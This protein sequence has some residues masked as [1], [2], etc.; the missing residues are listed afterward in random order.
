LTPFFKSV[1]DR[2][3]DD[4]FVALAPDLHLGATAETPDEAEALTASVDP[5]RVASL[6]RSSASALVD[7][8]ATTAG[9]IGVVGFS[10][11]ASWGMWLSARAPDLVRAV[12][13]FYGTTDIDFEASRAA[14]LGHFA[15]HDE[16]VDEDDLAELHA[17]LRLCGRDVA[18][19]QYPGTGHWFFEDDRPAAYVGG[20]AEQ[21]WERTLRFLHDQLP[22]EED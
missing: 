4:G 9:P 6:V 12:V 8:P 19:H 15:E 13:A 18:F 14:Y 7:M 11:G 16:F 10:M 1:A 3:A 20:A 22:T 5:N 17:H 2:L 21:A